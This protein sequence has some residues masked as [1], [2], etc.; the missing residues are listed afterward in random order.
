MSYPLPPEPRVPSARRPGPR[1]AATIAAAVVAAL[2][3]L[4]EFGVL[5][6]GAG[7][8]L[9]CDLRAVAAPATPARRRIDHTGRPGADSE[10]RTGV[11]TTPGGAALVR[12]LAGEYIGDRP[13][14]HRVPHT[15][16]DHG[17][18]RESR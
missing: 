2:L 17:W 14:C 12:A 4:A 1:A 9:R 18:L 6:D 5:G 3:S 11:V 10:R 13:G 8:A 7:I 15:P 16:C